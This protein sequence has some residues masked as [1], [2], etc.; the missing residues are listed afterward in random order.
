[1]KRK[2]MAVLT[3]CAILSTLVSCTPK[4]SADTLKIMGNENDVSAGYMQ[5]IFKQYE[6]ATGKKLEIIPIKNDN[7]AVYAVEE[8]EKGNVPDVFMSFNDTGLSSSFDVENTFYYLN[9]ESWV[10]DLT[11]SAFEACVDK[12]G[13]LLG[14]PFWENSLSGCYYNKTILDSLGLKPAVTQT[15]FDALCQA[16]LNI[17]Y[18]PICWPGKCGWMYQ[19]GLDTI[20][21]DNPELLEKLNK[22][23]INYA[24][25]PEVRKMVQWIY[26]AYKKGWFGSSYS[27]CGWNDIGSEL[28]SGKAVMTFIWDSWFY[29]QFDDSTSKYTKDD[30]ALMPVFMNTANRGMYEGGNLSM[31]MVNKNSEKRDEALDFLSFC[32]APE[33]YNIAFDGVSTQ[34]V[35]KGQTTN[36]QSAMVTDNAASVNTYRRAS[37]AVNKIIGY[38]QN[39]M[40]EIFKSLFNGSTD[41]D[42]CV[43]L[44]DIYRKT[45]AKN[46]GTAGF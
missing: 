35:F 41:V 32:A 13:N 45:T 40:I 22:N 43:D 20:F 21:A 15:E 18:T 1:M 3:V 12:D 16:L 36:I 26:D 34:N 27:E 31:L 19:F 5:S 11:D 25:I 7:F 14:L 4:D 44:M 29:S 39:D 2:L 17:G 24:D 23:E 10:G 46:L 33:N 9:D 37:T 38:K 42:G 8:F 30:F 6:E 28:G